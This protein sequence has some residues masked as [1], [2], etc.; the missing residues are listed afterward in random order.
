MEGPG[1][2]DKI[3]LHTI[4][5][6]EAKG[7]S[8][9]FW[10]QHEADAASISD[11]STLFSVIG[12]D[13]SIHF[14]ADS[15]T[16]R[17]TIITA[18]AAIVSDFKT[19]KPV[20]APVPS[21]SPTG[22]FVFGKQAQAGDKA[23]LTFA[24]KSGGGG[25]GGGTLK[26]FGRQSSSS[27]LTTSPTETTTAATSPAAVVSPVEEK[28]KDNHDE[29]RQIAAA[30][31]IALAA[32]Q[33]KEKDDAAAAAT[34]AAAAHDAHQKA[35]VDE[36]AKL[37]R[38]T[39]FYAEKAKE[40]AAVDT[41]APAAASTPASDTDVVASQ[42]VKTNGSTPPATATA[43][44]SDDD[45]KHMLFRQPSSSAL[46]YVTDPNLPVSPPAAHAPS[47]TPRGGPIAI[48]ETGTEFT[49]FFESTPGNVSSRKLFFFF[50]AVDGP[51]M[52]AIYWCEP[53]HR[54]KKDDNR[55]PFARISDVF[56]GKQ[57]PILQSELAKPSNP[58]CCF[59]LMAGKSWGLHLAAENE[60]TRQAW[61]AGI[62]AV[63]ANS[64]KAVTD[65]KGA[66][67]SSSATP[68]LPVTTTPTPAATPKPVVP[69]G[70]EAIEQ[71]VAGRDFIWYATETDV[72]AGTIH[73]VSLF[74]M[75]ETPG[76]VSMCSRPT[77]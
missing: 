40:E 41:P 8:G 4:T 6:I 49:T 26:L 9:S 35:S 14:A 59:S 5:D 18:L 57:T 64:G 48:L 16:H 54:T 53:G 69:S 23:P 65:G 15:K 32:I 73:R 55:L 60:A 74:Y 11:P 10:Q 45:K 30:T 33:Q 47:S 56:M 24:A 75:A 3:S 22:P 44:T 1:L 27:T 21:T 34:A 50:E 77:Q 25:G 66:S 7:T 51:V 12:R 2:L 68:A 46:P 19:P 29:E 76:T 70:P 28:K 61:L 17:D 58:K 39:T 67:S 31:D 62:R 52:G 72:K 63:F 36:A 42:D 20:V 38:L 13:N 43:T 71:F 37:A